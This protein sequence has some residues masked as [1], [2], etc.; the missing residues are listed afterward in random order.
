MVIG[1]HTLRVMAPPLVVSPTTVARFSGHNNNLCNSH[2]H[3]IH[4]KKRGKFSARVINI[5][6]FPTQEVAKYYLGRRISTN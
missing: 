5:D 1:G 3:A 6:Q 2:I 4:D